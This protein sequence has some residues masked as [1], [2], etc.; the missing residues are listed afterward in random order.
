MEKGRGDIDKFIEYTLLQ[1][2]GLESLMSLVIKKVNQ[3]ELDDAKYILQVLTKKYP[4]NFQIFNIL[5]VVLKRKKEYQEALKAFTRAAEISPKFTP[6][7]M[8]IGNLFITIGK[9]ERAIDSF[10]AA[11]EIDPNIVSAYNLKG[12]VLSKMMMFADAEVCFNKAIEIDDKNLDVKYNLAALYYNTRRYSEAFKLIEYL[13]EIVPDNITYLLFKARVLEN[14]GRVNEAIEVIKSILMQNPNNIESIISLANIYA[15]KLKDNMS[16]KNLYLEYYSKN[17]DSVVLMQKLCF[18]LMNIIHK[19]GCVDE[20]DLAVSI[21][22]RLLKFTKEKH[23]YSSILQLL[24]LESLCHDEYEKLGDQKD[25]MLDAIEDGT[26]TSLIFSMSR[27]KSIEDRIQVIECHKYLGKRLEE[28][29]LK[30][31]IKKKIRQRLSNKKRIGMFSSYL[32]NTPVGYFAWP[33]IEKID[34]TKFEVYCYSASPYTDEVRIEMENTAD[35]FTSYG[36]YDHEY[37][38]AQLMYE[39]QLDIVFEMGGITANHRMGAFAYKIAPIQV[40]WLGYPQSVGL[41]TSID[42]ILTDKYILPQDQRLIIEKPL[43]MPESWVVID[44]V[45]FDKVN[46]VND[47]PEDRCGVLTFGTLNAPYKYTQE[48]IA[49]WAEIMKMVPNSRFLCVRQHSR[50]KVFKDNFIMHMGKHG[51]TQDRIVFIATDVNHL[52]CY[53]YIDIALDTFPHTGGTTTCETLWM[54]VPLV[55]LVGP[56]FFERI[57]YS[58]LSNVE[59]SDLCAYSVEGYKK[60]AVG[61]AYDKERRRALRR[62]LR[63]VI[64][65]SPLGQPERFVRNFEAKI[66]EVI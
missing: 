44:K 63:D 28:K 17:P 42:Y 46:I 32:S 5:G 11:I 8:N 50:Y 6:A 18:F 58:N 64:L 16:A 65:R 21:G 22:R 19:K 12:K 49:A 30:R 47:I 53:N 23:F 54:G 57:S 26:L 24:F 36:M 35:K 34:R 1:I 20:L 40:S 3:D 56:C 7:V 39:D 25:L 9:L 41:P 59:L 27:V 15:N 14:I 66:L 10:N 62:T 43:V 55:T 38:V 31:P 52:E 13:S 2:D 61:L 48:A 33:V 29:A 37:E 45:G 51:I 4:S 60:I